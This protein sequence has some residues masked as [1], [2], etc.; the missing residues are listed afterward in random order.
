[1]NLD[2]LVKF[3]ND[4]TSLDPSAPIVVQYNRENG[5]IYRQLGKV[6]VV[7]YMGAAY[8]P[9]PILKLGILTPK[10]Y[11]DLMEGLRK[12]IEDPQLKNDE[13][14]IR[15]K[16]YGTEF[17]KCYDRGSL[18]GPQLYVVLDYVTITNKFVAK[19][20]LNHHNPESKTLLKALINESKS[21][22]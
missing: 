13:L 9:N 11:S 16:D 22:K 1:M 19:W 5:L 2:L 4:L 15:I 8:F 18:S 6:V 12:L 7:P 3:Y 10:G 14:G 21:N 17:Y 20:I